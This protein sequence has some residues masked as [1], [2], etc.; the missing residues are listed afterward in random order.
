MYETAQ[1]VTT[2]DDVADTL[3][4]IA[5]SDTTAT[6]PSMLTP[7]AVKVVHPEPSVVA[8]DTETDDKEH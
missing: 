3:R 1:L 2:T 4:L 5:A 6:A 8:D 7:D